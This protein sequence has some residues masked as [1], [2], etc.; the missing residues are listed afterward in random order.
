LMAPDSFNKLTAHA[1][2]L[3]YINKAKIG[4]NL[5]ARQMQAMRITGM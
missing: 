5:S 1:I 3:L 4:R 2:L